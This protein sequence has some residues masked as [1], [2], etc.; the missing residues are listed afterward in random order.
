MQT[1]NVKSIVSAY[2]HRQKKSYSYYNINF[3]T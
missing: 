2:L 3:H 1:H